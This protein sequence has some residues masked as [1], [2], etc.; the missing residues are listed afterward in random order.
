MN[1]QLKLK[2]K[3][4]TGIQPQQFMVEMTKNKEQFLNWYNLFTWKEKE[5][6]SVFRI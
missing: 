4:G 6:R 3:I 1:V 5:E 2:N